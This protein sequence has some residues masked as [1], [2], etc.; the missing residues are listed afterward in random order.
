MNSDSIKF[1]FWGTSEFSVYILNSLKERGFLPSLIVSTPDKPQGRKLEI[2]PTHTKTWAE[3]HNIPVFQP[4][5]LN[6][7]AFEKLSKEEWDVFIV[8][9][10]GKIIPERFLN[11]PKSK[12]LNVHPSLLPELRGP[13]P[14]ES[15]ILRDIKNTGVSIMQLDKEMD[16]GPI[17]IQKEYTITEWPKR[18]ELEKSFG[19]LGGELLADILPGWING[20]IQEKEQDHSKATYCKKI[21]KQ[22][23]LIDMSDEPYLNF[24]KIQAYSGWPCAFFFVKNNEKNIRVVVKDAEFKNG[25]L[26]I[27]RVIPEGKKEMSYQDFLRGLK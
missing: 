21:E 24:R 19:Y 18:E 5:K 14:I 6:D 15:C 25:E 3:I 22:E 2:K 11:I 1:V 4:E 23:A 26:I 13:S 27:A 9:S 8:A 10:Y 20:K 17:V 7:E 16:H 12:T